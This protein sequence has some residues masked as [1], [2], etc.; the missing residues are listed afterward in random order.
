M[1]ELEK[2]EVTKKKAKLY[3]KKDIDNLEKEFMNLISF[4]DQLRYKKQYLAG[5]INLLENF[6]WYI[7]KILYQK[8]CFLW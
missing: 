1:Q 2:R 6:L 7:K 3:L 4:V 8:N 5:K